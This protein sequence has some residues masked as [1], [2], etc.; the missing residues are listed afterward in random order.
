MVALKGPGGLDLAGYSQD[1]VDVGKLPPWMMGSRSP[2]KV[3]SR[4]MMPESK[5]DGADDIGQ[6]CRRQHETC[7][8]CSHVSVVVKCCHISHVATRGNR[9]TCLS[10]GRMWSCCTAG[11]VSHVYRHVTWQCCRQ[12]PGGTWQV[13][14]KHHMLSCH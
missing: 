8:R 5:E 1:G 6:L 9:W 4:V 14:G 11:H 7:G 3:C 2:T 12:E 10:C 13:A